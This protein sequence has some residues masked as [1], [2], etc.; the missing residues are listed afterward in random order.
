MKNHPDEFFGWFEFSPTKTSHVRKCRH[1]MQTYSTEYLYGRFSIDMLLPELQ[2]ITNEDEC[3]L[4]INKN[5][6]IHDMIDSV[7]TELAS[8]ESVLSLS[9]PNSSNNG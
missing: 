3:K 7:Q 6:F 5:P 8:E 1:Q 9:I 2:V 4:G